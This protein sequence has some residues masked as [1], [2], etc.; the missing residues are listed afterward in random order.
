MSKFKFT[1]KTGTHVSACET[2]TKEKAWLWISKI[3]DLSLEQSK[4]LYNIEKIN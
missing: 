1:T 4:G 3:K 2:D